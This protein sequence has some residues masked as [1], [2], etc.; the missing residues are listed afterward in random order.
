MKKIAIL[1]LFFVTSTILVSCYKESVDSAEPQKA[2]RSDREARTIG[3]YKYEFST[4]NENDPAEYNDLG[5]QR[6]YYLKASAG[7][8]RT[9]T[10]TIT[11]VGASTVDPAFRVYS[12][13]G[14][15]IS[16]SSPVASMGTTSST[17]FYHPG[18]GTLYTGYYWSLPMGSSS[19]NTTATL[20]M[21]IGGS[22]TSCV[23]GNSYVDMVNPYSVIASDI[24]FDLDNIGFVRNISL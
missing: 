4:P 17:G 12:K 21:T 24:Y 3:P 13:Q 15:C 11:K 2:T 5:L 23:E 8:V 22:S 14:G 19:V 18:N 1:S 16:A 6:Q 10:L 20:T 9:L 7:Y